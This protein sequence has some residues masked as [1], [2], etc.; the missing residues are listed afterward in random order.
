MIIEASFPPTSLNKPAV[1]LIKL[2]IE[3][4]LFVFADSTIELASAVKN[5]GATFLADCRIETIPSAEPLMSAVIIS[6]F[7]DVSL[8]AAVL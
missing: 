5:K 6:S 4:G 7:G 8:V 1:W 2:E 3:D